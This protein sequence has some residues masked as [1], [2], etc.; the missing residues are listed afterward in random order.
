MEDKRICGCESCENR[1]PFDLPTEIID[2]TI[3]GNLVIFAGAGISTETKKIFKETL[4]EDI[5]DEIIKKPQ[6]ELDFPSLM[7]L[8]CK[9]TKNGRQ[10]LLQTIKYRFD[11]C[12]QFQELYNQ[13]SEFHKELSSIYH[14]K[15]I[16]TTNWD[17]FFERE[18]GA[19]PIVIPEDFA[20]HNLPGRK[21][22]KIHGSISNY[23]SIIA[24]KEDYDKCYKQLNRGIIGSYLKTI[25][26]TKTVV[27]IGYSFR[28][29]DFIR[30]YN[31]LKKELKEILPHCYIVTVNPEIDKNFKALNMTV[32]NTNGAYFISAIRKHLEGSKL[33]FPKENISNIYYLKQKHYKIHEETSALI[34]EKRTANSIYCALYQDGISHALSY[35]MYHAD[36][37]LS[38]YPHKIFNSIDSY[39]EIRKLKVKA[40]NYPDVAYIDGYIEGLHTILFEEEDLESFPFWYLYG[41]GPV[42]DKNSFEESIND[43]EIFHKAAEN[44][45]QKTFKD[46]LQGTSDLVIHHRPFI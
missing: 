1:L 11:Y 26:A 2:A 39:N 17:D 19:I 6:D 29:Y 28:D 20:F 24:T 16:V 22:Y 31:Y 7:S 37:G 41:H 18:A 13:A 30:I 44:F 27:F 15:S 35:L 14:I 34:S 21:V 45:A 5:L 4:Y 32:I 23:G 46:I 25:L 10:K 9:T 3:E 43:N 36:S 33:L 8:F 12:H 42:E 40:K 38:F